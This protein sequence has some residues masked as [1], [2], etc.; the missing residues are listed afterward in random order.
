MMKP[1]ATCLVLLVLAAPALAAQ[2]E[3]DVVIATLH[4]T[5][6]TFRTGNESLAAEYLGDGFTLTDTSGN[7]TTREQTLLELRNKEPRYEVFRNHDMKVRL[8]GDTA[9]VNGI[10]SVKG[11]AGGKAF[12]AELRFTDTLVKRNGRW[13]VV[14]SHVSPMPKP[15]EAKQGRRPA[16]TR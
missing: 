16:A 8:Y 7:V 14:A 12:A 10:T 2:K 9:V 1:L 13:R 11:V 6:E 4:S 3:E 5:C 15:A